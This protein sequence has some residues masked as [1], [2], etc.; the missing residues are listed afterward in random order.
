MSEYFVGKEGLQ[1]ILNAARG[2]DFDKWLRYITPTSSTIKLFNKD[3]WV[4]HGT[5][6]TLAGGAESFSLT[7]TAMS[8]SEY[9][10]EISPTMPW[11]W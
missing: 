3:I 1:F 7:L 6:N 2:N 8:G 4:T 10:L 11:K 9:M 5:T